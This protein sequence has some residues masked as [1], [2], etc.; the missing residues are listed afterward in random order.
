MAGQRNTVWFSSSSQPIFITSLSSYVSARAVWGVSSCLQVSLGSLPGTVWGWGVTSLTAPLQKG[1]ET[2]GSTDWMGTTDRW[3][4]GT[5][6]SHRWWPG[7][8][9]RGERVVSGYGMC[10]TG[11][12]WA[13]MCGHSRP[14]SPA[15]QFSYTAVF[16]AYTAFLFIRT[17]WSS[18][19]PGSPGAH[20]CGWEK[21]NTVDVTSLFCQSLRQTE[22]GPSAFQV[23]RWK[24]RS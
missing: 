23:C 15:F 20:R 19:F 6:D 8:H 14:P 2:Q 7:S 9:C 21:G 24:Q 11:A 18:V 12:G 22:P 16:G 1:L 10:S 4:W 3:R 13:C 17:G 5:E